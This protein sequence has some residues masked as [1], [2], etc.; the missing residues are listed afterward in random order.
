MS[1]RY[2]TYEAYG[3]V[4]SEDTMKLICEKA[5][6][7]DPV[8]DGDYGFALYEAGICELVGDFTGE[9]STIT[10]EGRDIWGKAETIDDSLFYIPVKKYPSL[11]KTAYNNMD[12][13]VAEFKEALGEYLPA[14]FDYRSNIRHIV[15]TTF[16]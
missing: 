16:G 5:F 15:G 7:E 1:M 8:E 11:F 3:L 6:A 9:L 14:D 2:Y 13:L 12:E 4:L 10:D